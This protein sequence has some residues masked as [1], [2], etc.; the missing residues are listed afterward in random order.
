VN[1]TVEV[2]RVCIQS[3]FCSSV[4]RCFI[5]YRE[6]QPNERTGDLPMTTSYESIDPSTTPDVVYTPIEKKPEHV[7]E[8]TEAEHDYEQAP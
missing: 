8:N 2:V 7:Y 4:K 3:T 5:D 1:V 6:Q